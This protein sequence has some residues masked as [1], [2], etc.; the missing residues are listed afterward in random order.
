MSRVTPRLVLGATSSGMSLA[1]A[2]KSRVRG[3]AGRSDEQRLA[4]LAARREVGLGGRA[5]REVDG[6]IGL[7]ERGG[8]IGC[9]VTPSL[10]S[11]RARLRPCR[12]PRF[13]AKP[14]PRRSRFL[15]ISEAARTSARPIRPL[16]PMMG[17]AE[18][19]VRAVTWRQSRRSASR[20]RRIPARAA[21]AGS[22][23]V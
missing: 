2:S 15:A 13:E 21:H 12:E 11:R 1:A 7:G 14:P 6:D 20:P 9:D 10:P 23:S 5:V 16:M 19:P 17:G 18:P 22:N 4:R 3:V 8:Q